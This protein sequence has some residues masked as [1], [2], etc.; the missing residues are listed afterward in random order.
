L[1]EK[2]REVRKMAEEQRRAY[3]IRLDVEE[4]EGIRVKYRLLVRPAQLAQAIIKEL[5]EYLEARREAEAA[6]A[7]LAGCTLSS[8]TA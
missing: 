2:Y 1:L 5:R 7:I 8:L 4:S 6:A 3:A